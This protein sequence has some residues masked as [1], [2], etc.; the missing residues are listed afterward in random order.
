MA[1]IERKNLQLVELDEMNKVHFEEL[2]IVNNIFALIELQE[3][4]ANNDE[5]LLL[6]LD[7]FVKHT[8]GHFANEERLMNEFMFPATHCHL[9][10]HTSALEVIRSVVAEYKESKNLMG[11]KNYFKQDLISWLGNH[12]ATMD[13]VTASFIAQQ[14]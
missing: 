1:L 3:A 8:E 10:E 9:A 13:N 14:R 11:L 6:A 5:E 2:E 4:G 12:I 7:G